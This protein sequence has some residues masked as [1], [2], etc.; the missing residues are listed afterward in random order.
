MKTIRFKLTQFALVLALVAIAL[1][2]FALADS[3]T[4]TYRVTFTA[5]WSNKTHPHSG[6]PA[7]AFFSPLI[8]GVHSDQ[9]VYWKVGAPASPAITLMAEEGIPDGLETDVKAD[10]EHGS[11]LAVLSSPMTTDSPGST[12]IAAFQVN[13]DYPLVTL[14]SMFAPTPDWF[15]GVSGLSLLDENGNWVKSKVVLLYPFDAG[16][17]QNLHYALH[18][19]PEPTRRPIY[20]LSGSEWFT[21]EP[22]G[23]FNFTRIK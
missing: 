21:K 4:A 7:H 10:I 13:T 8:G 16:T 11:A 19:P 12:T 3:H 1:P 20:S 23:N 5:T 6:F 9:A 22:V 2:H 17:Q 14:V 15:T 18:Q